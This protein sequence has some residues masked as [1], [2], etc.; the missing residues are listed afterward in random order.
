M[1]WIGVSM[2]MVTDKDSIYK[3]FWV[4]NNAGTGCRHTARRVD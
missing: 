1:R 4:G 2:R 3:F